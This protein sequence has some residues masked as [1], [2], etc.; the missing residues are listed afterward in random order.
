MEKNLL[1]IVKSCFKQITKKQLELLKKNKI[2]ISE[3]NNYDS[4]NFMK[5][6]FEIENKFKIKV[7]KSNLHKFYDF[8]K[9]LDYIHLKHKKKL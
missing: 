7:N 8:K 1:K 9:I 2:K 6:V 3:L 4:L 5:F